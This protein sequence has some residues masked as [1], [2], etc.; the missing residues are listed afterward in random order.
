MIEL[1]MA[2]VVFL[3]LTCRQMIFQW[4]S[5]NKRETNGRVP[6]GDNAE[7]DLVAWITPSDK[8]EEQETRKQLQS[9][10]E[11]LGLNAVSLQFVL[12]N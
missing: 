6:F 3:L 9:S 2:K 12:M 1:S 7:S 11:I 10:C 4:A 8:D 5:L